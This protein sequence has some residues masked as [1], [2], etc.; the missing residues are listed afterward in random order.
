MSDPLGGLPPQAELPEPHEPQREPIERARTPPRPTTWALLIVLFVVFA[1]E[2]IVGRD[3]TGESELALFR[4]GAL[5]GPAVRDGDWWRIGSYAF[6]HIG[7]LHIAFNAYA[8]WI[9][10]PQLEWTF[11]SN[12]TLGL[13]AA[14]ALAGGAAS[15]AWS[16]HTDQARFAAGASGGIFGLF[17]AT[18]G[19]YFRVRH[20]LSDD[21]RRRIIRAIGINLLI[22]AAIAIKAPV[23]NAAHLGGL[24]SGT[25]LA[26]V[27]PLP[28]LDPRPWHGVTRAV[29]IASALALAAMEGAAVARAVRPRTR[30]LRGNGAEA[31]VSGL[32]VPVEPGIAFLPGV[33]KIGIAREAAP[34]SIT[35]GED[36][37][38]IGDRT[39]LRQRSSEDG[40]DYTRL[41]AADDGGRLIIEF[42]CG[43]PF[44]RGVGADRLIEPTAR[45]IR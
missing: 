45:T 2:M 9:L 21:V 43:D 31:Q 23:D 5:F 37:V 44:C 12:L 24:V 8:L 41:A 6:L 33:A 3:T 40:T 28:R 36:A 14:T 4:L 22:N 25:L 39:W 17:G 15:T 1:A 29:L 20:N 26:L 13:F 35:P 10:G 16:F 27:A 34:L 7:W 32:L 11:G 18:I 42:A 38:H 30:T 19:L